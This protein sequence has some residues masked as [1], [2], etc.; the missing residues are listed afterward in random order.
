MFRSVS[1]RAALVVA[2]ASLLSQPASPQV[3]R[4]PRVA[5][6][7]ARPVAL[8][9]VDLSG[10]DVAQLRARPWILGQTAPGAMGHEL[11]RRAVPNRALD[12]GTLEARFAEAARSY[13]AWGRVDDELRWAPWLCRQPQPS[14]PRLSAA[15]AGGHAEKVYFLYARDRDAYLARAAAPGQ[16]VVKESWTHRPTTLTTAAQVHATPLVARTP[17]G[18][19]VEPDRAAGL[20]V[21][22]RVDPRDP[23][24]DHGWAYGTVAPDG[25]VTSAGPLPSCMGCHVEAGPGRLFGLHPS[26]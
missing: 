21:M 9:V 25:R 22:M 13:L 6:P 2:C 10:W 18:Q 26:R 14:V 17:N 16:V 19:W 11:T 7:P 1:S 20:F 15:E 3:V 4:S 23:R 5:P 12:E 24:G 8:P